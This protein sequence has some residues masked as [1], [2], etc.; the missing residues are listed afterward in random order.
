MAAF[1]NAPKKILSFSQASANN[2][3][4]EEPTIGEWKAIIRVVKEREIIMLFDNAFQGFG[5]GLKEDVRIFSIL[6]KII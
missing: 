2:P 4:D 1:K 6:L 5:E 3:T